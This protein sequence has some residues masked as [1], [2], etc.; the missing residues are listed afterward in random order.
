MSGRPRVFPLSLGYVRA[1]SGMSGRPRVFPGGLGYV[2]AASGISGRPRICPGGIGYF[3]ATSDISAEPRVFPGGL[4]YFRATSGMS[5]R[6]RVFPGSLRRFRPV[7]WWLLCN[8]GS[9]SQWRVGRLRRR[10]SKH[11]NLCVVKGGIMHFCRKWRS[12]NSGENCPFTGLGG[13]SLDN[14]DS[15]T[16]R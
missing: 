8:C 1:A 5:G 12:S 7:A 9:E 6:P 4:G 3:R 13:N 15:W 14:C 11:R 10:S 16:R 2:R